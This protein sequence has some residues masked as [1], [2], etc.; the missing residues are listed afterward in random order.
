MRDRHIAS[1]WDPGDDH[2]RTHVKILRAPETLLFK[3]LPSFRILPKASRIINRE[4]RKKKRE[5][6]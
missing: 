2:A 6:E 4:T 3:T 5:K 1:K